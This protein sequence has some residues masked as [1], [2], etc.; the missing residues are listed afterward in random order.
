M[1]DLLLMQFEGID[2]EQTAIDST[3]RHT[4]IV[5]G[6]A[7]IDTT[8]KAVGISSMHFPNINGYIKLSDHVDFDFAARADLVYI[9][10]NRLSGRG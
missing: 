8:Y 3:N 7:K 1:S 10:P 4:P 9:K 5:Y 2:G 6:D